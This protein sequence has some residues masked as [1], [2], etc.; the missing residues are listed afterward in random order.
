MYT[1]QQQIVL[2]MKSE[3]VIKTLK[4]VKHFCK[5]LSFNNRVS[6][7]ASKNGYKKN[8]RQIDL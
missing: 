7:V 6:K 3:H 5:E 2:T 4:E 8:D 1:A